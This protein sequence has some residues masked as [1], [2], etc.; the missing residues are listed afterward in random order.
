VRVDR[1]LL[2]CEHAAA[3]V[4]A[5]WV[6]L[7]AGRERLLASHRGSDPGALALARGLARRLGVPL[8]ACTTTRLLADANR[9]A[10]H[11]RRFSEWTRSLPEPERRRILARCWAPHRDAVERAVEA[12]LRRG[13]RV[14]HLSV[15]SFAPRLGGRSR[16]CDVGLLYDPAR[17]GERA[18]CARWRRALREADP[19]LRVRR[20]HP[21]RGRAD[22]LTTALRRRFAPTRYLGIELE[23]SQGFLRGPRTA[24]LTG[25]LA[26][27]LG[28]AIGF[29]PVLVPKIRPRTPR[30]SL[31]G[32]FASARSARAARRSR[33]E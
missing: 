5:R 28:R 19:R 31:D 21:Y 9:S 8:Y 3:R 11:P 20:N 7:F 24:A 6:P 14:L 1:V 27:S 33:A 10:G 17:A 12:A 15:H 18:L 4:P 30:S 32:L 25:T 26:E 16:A 29:G 13:G 2:S 23:V 22:G